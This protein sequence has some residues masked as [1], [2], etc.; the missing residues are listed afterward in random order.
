M[1]LSEINQTRLDMS[2]SLAVDPLYPAISD[3]RIRNAYFL[4]SRQR[5][6]SA[7]SYV[8]NE[9]RF[10]PD[11]KTVNWFGFRLPGQGFA[12]RSCDKL[13]IKVCV[14][15]SK[16]PG[17][18]SFVRGFRKRCYRSSC[19]ICVESWANRVSASSTRRIWE[20]RS[21]LW[22]K[23]TKYPNPFAFVISLPHHMHG[24]NYKEMK[25]FF[26]KIQK[27]VGITASADVYHPWYFLPPELARKAY[28]NS[29]DVDVIEHWS[30][31]SGKKVPVFWPHFH[32]I[33][34]GGI[35]GQKVIQLE[36]KYGVVIRKFR[37]VKDEGEVFRTMKYMLSHCGVR[38]KTHAVVYRGDISYS[39]LRLPKEIPEPEICPYCGL[40]LR[41]GRIPEDK[42]PFLTG[43]PPPFKAGEDI[44]TDYPVEV[45][46][47]YDYHLY[48]DRDYWV[49][50][51]TSEV[52][53][54]LA[55]KKEKLKVY[56]EKSLKRA[57][58]N[59]TLKFTVGKT[60][61]LGQILKNA[62]SQNIVYVK[63]GQANQ[64]RSVI[65]G[66]VQ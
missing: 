36:K 42:L 3:N 22:E 50:I 7:T 49:V 35:D 44:L 9:A 1:Q 60:L 28:D 53:A 38:E 58:G 31:N 5:T 27:E 14:N 23:N 39:K 4:S 30:D 51:R 6:K 21:R 56:L 40:E 13:G 11:W 64:P 10:S 62:I 59:D 25:R 65:V 47:D 16:H 37:T 20:Y 18:K 8:F 41:H 17:Q 29:L 12:L 43:I 15:H 45:V 54:D 52:Q 66:A 33:G 63:L 55:D 24:L 2:G 26:T 57:V 46:Y 48:D 61:P 19:P 32:G 34:F